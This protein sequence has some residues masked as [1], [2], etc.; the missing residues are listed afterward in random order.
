[1]SSTPTETPDI[2]AASDRQATTATIDLR[3][4]TVTRPTPAM[5]AAMA[6]AEVGDDVYAEDPT[7]NLL[8]GRAAQIFG[9][10]AAIFVPTGTMGNQIAIRLH[11]HHGQEVV[12]ESRAHVVDWEMAMA[13][14][15][16]G[17]QLR[18]VFAERGIVT[19]SQIE[20]ALKRADFHRA[21][22]GLIT[23]ENTHNMAGG[24]AT[25]LEVHEEIWSRAADLGLPVHLDGAR[26]FNAATALEISVGELT[27]GFSSVMFCLSKG[28]C[29]PVG[30]MLVGSRD[31]VDRA[32]TVR[33]MLGGG[34]RQAGIL[35]A[36]GLIAL[37]EMP[38]RLGVDHA[39][40]RFLAES[41]A[42]L[43]QVEIDLTTVQTN[44][45]I[46]TLRDYSDLTPI[47]DRLK[48]HGVVAGTAADHQIRFVTHNDV[49][50]A[51]CEEAARIAAQVITEYCAEGIP[52]LGRSPRRKAAES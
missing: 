12:T 4:D 40:A 35:A 44:I 51:A 26:I 49:D 6:A 2:L 5:R 28:L 29:A 33:K 10:E 22:T 20:Q 50:R 17:V 14:A 11:T 3:S 31:F 43:P 39:N 34:M 36:A 30:S 21:G 13:A 19:W 8:E 7:V 9:R 48:E 18:T 42:E 23:L 47:L 52:M 32:R 38:K 16:S 25:P 37:E 1:M 15:F 45:V 41:L 24:T 46:F 27:S